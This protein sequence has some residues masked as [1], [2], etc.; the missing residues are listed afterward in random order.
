MPSAHAAG[1]SALATAVGLNVGFESPLFAVT[2]IF[3]LVTM[4]DAQGVR[5]ATGRQAGVLNK[6]IDDI[7]L[8]KGI[9]EERLKELIGHTP[10]Q[11]IV[12]AL[13]GVVLALLYH[14]VVK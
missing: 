2:C 4:F 6:I 3:S 10:F 8:N 11:V 14:R 9:R 7:Y 1:V 13:L 5:R 12:G